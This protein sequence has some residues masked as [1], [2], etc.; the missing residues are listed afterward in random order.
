MEVSPTTGRA[1]KN[2]KVFLALS[3]GVDSTMAGYLMIQ[4]FPN[5]N[6]VGVYLNNWDHQEES[7]GLNSC[8]SE[9]EWAQVQFISQKLN[10]PTIK[11][12]FIKNYWNSVF[13]PT[14]NN[15]QLGLT[16]NP[17]ILCNKEVK[18]G[19]LWD[20]LK[21]YAAG[22]EFWLVTGHYATVDHR[23]PNHLRL[24]QGVDP[25]KDQT[26]YLA[27]LSQEKLNKVIFPLGAFYKKDIKQLAKDVGFVE[28]SEQ[29][30][31]MGICFIGK[32]STGFQQFLSNYLRKQQVKVVNW[33]NGKFITNVNIWEF[34]LGQ[35]LRG[36]GLGQRWYVGIKDAASSI[37]MAVNQRDHP[38]YLKVGRLRWQK[39]EVR[40]NQRKFTLNRV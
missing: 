16:P 34:T 31:S 10:I 21:H 26:Y 29:K 22:D 40:L 24:I 2:I 12:N 6:Y 15:Y 38:S 8:P 18:F 3:S 17:D 4:K 27:G 35:R 9:R 37:I 32:R 20:H 39:L 25:I 28:Q 14:L 13:E 30:E 23:N 1:N 5:L 36:T 19:V 11:L 33:K 7:G